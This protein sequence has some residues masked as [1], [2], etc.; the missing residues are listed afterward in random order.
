VY[1]SRGQQDLSSSVKRT[2]SLDDSDDED[3]PYLYMTA[4]GGYQLPPSAQSQTLLRCVAFVYGVMF[5][6]G[7]PTVDCK[8]CAWFVKLVFQ[9]NACLYNICLSM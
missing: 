1:S 6:P 4:I 8:L 5:K 3:D 9:K 7:A 2:S